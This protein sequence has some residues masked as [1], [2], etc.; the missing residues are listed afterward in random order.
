MPV[1]YVF[2]VE[3]Y[4]K[5]KSELIASN[6]ESLAHFLYSYLPPVKNEIIAFH[7]AMKNSFTC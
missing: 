3:L 6:L 1:I 7:R 4:I 5:L 2:R